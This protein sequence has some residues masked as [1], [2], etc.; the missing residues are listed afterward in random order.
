MP[1][2]SRA[3][4]ARERRE[5]QTGGSTQGTGVLHL[6]AGQLQGRRRRLLG[7][8]APADSSRRAVPTARLAPQARRTGSLDGGARHGRHLS[9]QGGHRDQNNIRSLN[10]SPILHRNLDGGERRERSRKG[11]PGFGAPGPRV[12]A[13]RPECHTVRVYAYG[14]LRS[15]SSTDLERAAHQELAELALDE[16]RQTGSVADVRPASRKARRFSATT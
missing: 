16:Q 3:D 13:S 11:R 14:S 10:R 6:G 8:V 9:R 1:L 7:P 12:H 15:V 4:P 2:S 5:G